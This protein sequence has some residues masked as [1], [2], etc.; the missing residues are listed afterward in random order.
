[1]TPVLLHITENGNFKETLCMKSIGEATRYLREHGCRVRNSTPCKLKGESVCFTNGNTIYE[2]E[3]DL[4]K[5]G[6][7]R[8]RSC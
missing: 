4:I 8:Q 5:N 1:M 6:E 2:L 7:R 3:E